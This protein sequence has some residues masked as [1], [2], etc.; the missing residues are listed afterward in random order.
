MRRPPPTPTKSPDLERPLR[1]AITGGIGAGKSEALAA[2]ARR[3]AAVASADEIVH[4][5]LRDDSELQAAIQAAFGVELTSAAPDER[6]R[7]AETVFG[8]SERVSKLEGLLHPRVARRQLAWLEELGSQ[9][10]PPA[11]AV[12]E[13]PLLYESGAEKRFDVVVAITAPPQLRAERKQLARL[14]ARERR[15]LPE[16]EKARRADFAY[17]NVGSRAELDAFVASVVSALQHSVTSF[18]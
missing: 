9:P 13:V 10:D 15:L 7:L 2:F 5:L 8:D 14:E 16:A 17:E 18:G 4:E 1:V 12:V 11:L 6:A 3:G